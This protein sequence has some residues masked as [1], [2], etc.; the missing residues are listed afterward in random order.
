MP[1][2]ILYMKFF[3]LCTSVT[4]HHLVMPEVTSL[5]LLLHILDIYCSLGKYI[6]TIIPEIL[7]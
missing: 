2:I 5:L 6:S 7:G 3:T 4:Y 1:D